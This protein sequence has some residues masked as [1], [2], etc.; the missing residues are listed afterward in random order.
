MSP[1]RPTTHASIPHSCA[2]PSST[3]PSSTSTSSTPPSSPSPRLHWA[4]R[5]LAVL[6]LVLPWAFN[7]SYF[8]SGGSIAPQVFWRDASANALATAIAL[9]VYLAAVAFA[10]WVLSERRVRRPWVDVL[11]CFA[12]G[13]SVALPVY[14]LRRSTRCE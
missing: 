12:V 3:S 1:P 13:L 2:S 9:D 4:L 11:L 7:L 5:I 8:A 14:L 10:C 6:G